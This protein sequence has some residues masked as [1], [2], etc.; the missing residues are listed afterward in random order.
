MTYGLKQD[1]LITLET[2]AG[3]LPVSELGPLIALL[4]EETYSLD[5]KGE[6][7]GQ[8]RFLPT[9]Q[10]FRFA[11]RSCLKVHAIN[12]YVDF[13][14]SDWQTFKRAIQVRNRITHPKTGVSLEVNDEEKLATIHS[15][16]WTVHLFLACY[17]LVH[18]KWLEE[19]IKRHGLP[20]GVSS[21]L[22]QKAATL[23]DKV[24][25][26]AAETGL[27]ASRPR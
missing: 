23:R 17:T 18:Q 26:I 10:N 24:D 7:Q 14:G 13:A 21:E 15:F 5:G 1:C 2:S 3:T 12:L 22:E 25:A 27:S 9:D 16:G 19:I 6:P 4:K 11:I 8:A 20:S